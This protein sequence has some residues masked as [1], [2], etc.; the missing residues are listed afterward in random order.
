MATL[1]YGQDPDS[2]ETDVVQFDIVLVLSPEDIGTLTKHP[3]EVGADVSDHYRDDPDRLS[4]EAKVSTIPHPRDADVTLSALDLTLRTRTTPGTKTITLDVPSPP[5]T[6]S[7]AGLAEAGINAIASAITGPPKAT[8][9]AEPKTR[10]V[11]ASAQ[12]WQQR[13]PRNRVRDVYDRLLQFK[14]KR[15]LA[16]VQPTMREYFDMMITRVAAPQTVEDGNAVTFGIDLER[17]RV[18]DS[19][20]VQS[21]EPAEARG[22]T[23][24]NKGTQNG[25]NDPNA[26]GKGQ[27]Y[28]STLSQITPG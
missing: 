3:V 20:T 28:E 25:K 1:I 7:L 22:Q 16:T 26:A 21:P 17:L 9:H 24:K 4:I 23:G 19:E 13:S 15:M 6:P 12:A 5:I 18:A 11:S 10:N 14:H 8:V 2:G 27:V